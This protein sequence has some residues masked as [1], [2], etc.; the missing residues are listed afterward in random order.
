MTKT[1]HAT[2]ILVSALPAIM[3]GCATTSNLPE[4]PQVPIDAEFPEITALPQLPDPSRVTELPQATELPQVTEIPQATELPVTSELPQASELS[5]VT[6]LSQAPTLPQA[7]AL[8]QATEFPQVTELSQATEL[9]QVPEPAEQTDF[10]QVEL[11]QL[12]AA[13]QVEITSVKE[14][15]QPEL[16]PVP[17]ASQDIASLTPAENA[18][19]ALE[20]TAGNAT[21]PDTFRSI[22]SSNNL[23]L[24]LV[25]NDL[26]KGLSFIPSMDPSLVSIRIST[27]GS[28]FDNVVKNSMER[29]GYN[30]AFGHKPDERQHLT[31]AFLETKQEQQ[32]RSLLAIMAING[33]LI[34]R[35]YQIQDN[36]IQPLTSYIFHGISPVSVV[37]N[38]LVEVL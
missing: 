28:E 14:V 17:D 31:T 25:A 24:E 3:L 30:F 16:Q 19:P 2:G 7:T 33:T 10:Q 1:P 37:S 29:I 21:L 13:P 5:Q 15:S 38:D 22:D 27:P 12:A 36:T 9:S 32:G 6:E 8:S 11:S 20:T 23:P 35:T 4:L 26:A 34:K 18:L